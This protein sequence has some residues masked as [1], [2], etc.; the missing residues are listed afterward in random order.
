M[1]LRRRRHCARMSSKTMQKNCSASRRYC[2]ARSGTR[3]EMALG[4]RQFKYAA[5]WAAQ[6]PD[7][8]I[9]EM[10]ATG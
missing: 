6:R 8:P 9:D 7:K 5:A 4:R 2:S 1:L 10:S 3:E